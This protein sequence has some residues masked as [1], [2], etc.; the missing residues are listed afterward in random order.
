ME[1]VIIKGK[2]MNIV[3]DVDVVAKMKFSDQENPIPT[4]E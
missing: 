1:T 3:T 4:I 2:N